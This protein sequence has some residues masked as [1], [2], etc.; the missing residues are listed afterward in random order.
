MKKIGLM[1]SLILLLFSEVNLIA[2]NAEAKNLSG[3]DLVR[4]GKLGSISGPLLEKE[5]EWYLKTKN[6][7]YNLHFGNHQYRAKTGIELKSEKT[8]TVKG[9]IHNKDVAVCTITINNKNYRFRQ[10]DGVALWSGTGN[11]QNKH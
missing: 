1:L 2:V 7:V 6:G 5:G 10:D 9:F 3:K 11:N 4:L 8:V